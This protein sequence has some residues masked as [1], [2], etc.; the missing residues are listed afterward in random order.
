MVS[1]KE[2][3]TDSNLLHG[4]PGS[5]SHPSHGA[6]GTMANPGLRQIKTTVVKQLVKKKVMHEK[7]AKQQEEKKKNES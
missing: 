3:G 7:E 1:W 5:L 2:L 6:W 4:Y